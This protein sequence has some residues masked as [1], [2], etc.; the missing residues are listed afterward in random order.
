LPLD[1]QPLNKTRAPVELGV[2]PRNQRIVT[3]RSSVGTV[4]IWSSVWT[5]IHP[6]G[7]A[8]TSEALLVRVNGI[9]HELVVKAYVVHLLKDLVLATR[10]FD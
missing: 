9:V 3:G 2:C 5:W 4:M 8:A 7:R 10:Q 1:D 6:C